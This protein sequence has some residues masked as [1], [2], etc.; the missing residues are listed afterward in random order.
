MDIVLSFLYLVAGFYMLIKGANFVIDNASALALKIGIPLFIV[1]LT[2]VA[3]GT[4][5]PELSVSLFSSIKAFQESIPADIAV[6]NIIGSNMANLTLIFGSAALFAPV[7]IHKRILK[8]DVP[9]LLGISILFVLFMYF[10]DEVYRINR[11]E[12]LVLILCFVM[13]MTIMIKQKVLED[14]AVDSNVIVWKAL[15]LLFIG[16]IGVIIG[17][18]LVTL[19]AERLSIS[20]LV[21]VFNMNPLKVTSLVGLSVVAVGTSLPEL[22]TTIIAVKKGSVDIAVGNVVGSNIFNILFVGGLSGLI[23]P[24]TLQ[25]DFLVDAIIVVVITLVLFIMMRMQIKIYKFVGYF[26][27]MSYVVYLVYIITRSI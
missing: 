12:A 14:V 6:G 15:L 17:G 19:S 24:L 3:F 22:V 1:G 27:L 10:F 21:D 8:Q 18:N 23:V 20:L 4:S 5:L 2:V 26:L 9:F 7:V 16:F 25:K 13:Y 11:I